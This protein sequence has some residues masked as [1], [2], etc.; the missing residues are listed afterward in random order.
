V[1]P[2]TFTVPLGPVIPISAMA[3]SVAILAG[4]TATQFW[5]VLAAILS[6]AVLYLTAVRARGAQ[7]RNTV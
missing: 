2:A 7:D 4:V 5:S 1:Q 3:T 6:G